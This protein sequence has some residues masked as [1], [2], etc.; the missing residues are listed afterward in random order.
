[1]QASK[2][3]HSG[4]KCSIRTIADVDHRSKRRPGVIMPKIIVTAIG[5]FIVACAL[6]FALIHGVATHYERRFAAARN[7]HAR[8]VIAQDAAQFMQRFALFN[9]ADQMEM[10]A[11]TACLADFRQSYGDTG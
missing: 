11:R 2:H 1:M 9:Q 10:R 4:R 5:S 3:I 6:A 8:C 7:D